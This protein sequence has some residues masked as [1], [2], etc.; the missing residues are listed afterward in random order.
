MKFNK[1]QA[2]FLAIL[3]GVT[4]LFVL[5]FFNVRESMASTGSGDEDSGGTG[6][7]PTTNDSLS[8]DSL[9]VD[10]LSVDSGGAAP[11]SE[12][13]VGVTNGGEALN[14]SGGG[15][16]VTRSERARH[17]N[18]GGAQSESGVGDEPTLVGRAVA[19]G[20]VRHGGRSKPRRYWGSRGTGDG[21]GY[22][23]NYPLHWSDWPWSSQ[24]RDVVVVPEPEAPQRTVI[25]K[26]TTKQTIVGPIMVA[27]GI[28]VVGIA[29]LR[30]RKR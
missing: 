20:R 17:T 12:G 25:I 26:Q 19:S 7:A 2:L 14:E 21:H 11:L 10:S 6:D 27:I 13:V 4:T 18:G 28:G 9:S 30:N 1:R 8:V 22:Y 16:V 5:R 15:D 3:V 24:N 23:W 29:L